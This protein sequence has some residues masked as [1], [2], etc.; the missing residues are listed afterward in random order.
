MLHEIV[1]IIH[2]SPNDK[3]RW[4]DKNSFPSL[5]PPPSPSPLLNFGTVICFLIRYG[6]D[7][8]SDIIH[9]NILP[10]GALFNEQTRHIKT[11]DFGI[12]TRFSCEDQDFKNPEG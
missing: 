5:Y 10:A 6:W 8:A 1:G 4:Q 12:A 2:I 9:K 3:H 11:I 7:K